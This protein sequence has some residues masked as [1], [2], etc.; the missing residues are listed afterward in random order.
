MRLFTLRLLGAC[1]LLPALQ[2]CLAGQAGMA[3]ALDTGAQ[4]FH[5]GWRLS[6]EPRVGPLQVFDN[7]ARTWLHF[8]PGQPVP[9]VFGL[10]NGRE[11]SLTLK[12]EGQ[13]QIVQGVWPQLLFRAGLSL[14]Q[15]RRRPGE[16]LG[17]AQSVQA[18][19]LN[20]LPASPSSASA[21]SLAPP[22][23]LDP[24]EPAS[25]LAPAAL[26]VVAPV[27]MPSFDLRLDDQTLRQALARWALRAGWV[28]QAEHWDLG[29]DLPVSAAADFSGDFKHAVQQLLKGTELSA[30]PA[31]PCFYSNQVLRV[32]AWSQ[33]CDRHLAAGDRS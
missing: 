15:A 26:P 10:R 12:P 3:P 2:G 6:G 13:F 11:Q 16:P 32:V 20:I 18:G 25:P 21:S 30:H 7:G 5:F 33:A 31:Q 28:F 22:T 8:A 1:L 29:V 17:V 24:V 14:A 23:P 27:S 4:A 19:A 9:A